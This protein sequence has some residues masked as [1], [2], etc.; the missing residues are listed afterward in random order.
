MT[1]D[2]IKLARHALGLPNRQKRSYRNRYHAAGS[3][4]DW[5]EMVAA[6]LATATPIASERMPDYTAFALTHRGAEMVLRKGE[7]LDSEDFPAE[8]A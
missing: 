8:A 3:H 5:S 6:G 4:P 1:P 7:K 2:Q